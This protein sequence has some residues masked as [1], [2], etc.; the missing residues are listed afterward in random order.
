M[1]RYGSSSN[2]EPKVGSVVPIEEDS[3]LE[4][5]RFGPGRLKYALSVE[6]ARSG[7]QSLALLE[8]I[9]TRT[10]S[11]KPEERWPPTVPLLGH[12]VPGAESCAIFFFNSTKRQLSIEAI[13]NLSQ[14]FIY[15]LASKGEGARLMR[16][17]AEQAKP[18]LV[19]YLPGN[20]Q[21]RSLWKLAHREG[22]R[23]IWL[24]PWHAL[25]VSVFGTFLFASGEVFSPSREA[26]A[27]VTLLTA[28]MS[29]MLH[30]ARDRQENQRFGAALDNDSEI[31]V[32]IEDSQRIE[33]MAHMMRE[34]SR[35]WQ[36]KTTEGHE[37]RMPHSVTGWKKKD[38]TVL[39]M[40]EDKHGIPVIYDSST[41]EPRKR[42]EPDVVS[43]LSHELLSPLTL[44]KGYT[45]T[46]LQ[47][48]KLV[49]EEQKGQYL[50]GIESATNRVIRLLEN[51][52]E[53]ASLE[54][55]DTVNVQPTSLTNLLRKTTSEIQSQTTKHVIK[56]HS[57][58]PLPIVNVNQQKIEQVMTNLLV[59]AVK[60]SP[61][62]GDIETTTK[63]VRDEHELK[64]IYGE[65][66]PLRLPC[67]IVSVADSGIGIPEA[68]LDRIF[69]RYHR[70]D[71]K[72]TRT[73]PGAGFGLYICKM[74][75]EAHGG[76]IWA[77]NRS[78]GG[79]TFS[80]SLPVEP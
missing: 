40:Y 23:T 42:A 12:L 65:V 34:L 8:R 30:Q 51:L 44:I 57:F 10:V 63:L 74:I 38:T 60:Y 33:A 4:E 21:F 20:R 27:S 67:L 76:R 48:S 61:Q 24:V 71:N 41:H 55:T 3:L 15:A 26:L 28:L 6:E 66:P 47:L 19:I 70:V 17:A 31:R 2:R 13:A 50:R 78:E 46:L 54:E 39:R 79:S 59:N 80:F 14:E 49:T 9:A 68:E 73:T 58:A 56:F 77:R 1:A 5:S 22:I 25:D 29:T 32:G 7:D 45:A 53:I 64:E 36:E 18:Y 75:V 62:G 35:T 52:R 11:G 43:V 69:E 72:V 16:A 37:S